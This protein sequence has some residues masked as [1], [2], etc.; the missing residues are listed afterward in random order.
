MPDNRIFSTQNHSI[1]KGN[2]FLGMGRGSVGDVVFSRVN[3]QQ[4]ARARNRKPNNP[5][6]Q[7][8]MVQ[9]SRFA[10]ISKFYAHASKAFF[11]F[12]FENKKS[13]ESDYNA[14]MS[15]NIGI[16]PFATKQMVAN[17][18]TPF[19]GPFMLTS[20]SLPSVDDDIS[21]SNGSLFLKWQYANYDV[22][23][24]DLS[25]SMLED[26]GWMRPNDIVTLVLINASSTS[27]AV[28]TLGEAVSH[29]GLS[30]DNS[31]APAWKIVQFRIDTTNT[32][33]LTAIGFTLGGTSSARTISIAGNG[34]EISGGVF[35]V[36]RQSSEGLKVTTSHIVLQDT[37]MVAYNVGLADAW[38]EYCAVSWQANED[39]ILEGSLAQDG[40]IRITGTNIVF[41]ATTLQIAG[42]SVEF[43]SPVT[44]GQL[45][46]HFVLYD[47]EGAKATLSSSAGILYIYADGDTFNDVTIDGNKITFGTGS[48]SGPTF[49]RIAWE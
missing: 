37:A 46:S 21:V 38:A 48:S 20:G 26:N 23:I 49:S 47:T 6:T 19:F 17:P 15:A 24:A 16:T 42:K 36:S 32:A 22:T 1:M 18:N 44:L 45:E 39:A 4:T 14:F 30:F 8:Q 5:R 11:K 25:A 3:G 43:S 27:S 10:Y 35:V 33:S 41:P 31:I 7:S 13:I 2:L 9:R 40:R 34:S 29:D 28:E 12:A